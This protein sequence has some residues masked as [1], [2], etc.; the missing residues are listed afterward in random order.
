MPFDAQCARPLLQSCDLSTLFV[1]ELGWEPGHQELVIRVADQDYA[2]A[3]LAE[4][5]GFV[6]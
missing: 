1:E 6:A 2:F 3:A 4:K 5:R